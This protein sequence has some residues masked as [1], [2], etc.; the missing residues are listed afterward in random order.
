MTWPWMFALILLAQ[1]TGGQRADP[2]GPVAAARGADPRVDALVAAMEAYEGSIESVTWKQSWYAP[3]CT[4]MRRPDWLLGEESERYADSFWRWRQES[5]FFST[6]PPLYEV[7]YRRVLYFG[8]GQRRV[9]LP[10][11]DWRG[12]VGEPDGFFTGGCTLLRL[13][14]RHLDYG[15]H[16]FGRRPS[17][18]MR[19]AVALEYLEATAEVPWPGLRGKGALSDGTV[20]LEVR[21]DPD[22]GFAPRRF[23]TI[24]DRDG[25]TGEELFTVSYS[26]VD[27]VWIPSCGVC[28]SPYTE[29]VSDPDNPLSPAV[30]KD[31]QQARTLDGLPEG[32]RSIDLAAAIASGQRVRVIDA[33]NKIVEGPMACFRSEDGPYAPTVLQVSD[34]R[35]NGEVSLD[36]MFATLPPQASLMTGMTWKREPASLVRRL[37]SDLARPD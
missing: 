7:S 27:D 22:R 36:E 8:D 1:S 20:S 29:V 21:V 4:A 11:T 28:A 14:G 25:A 15:N 26:Q 16:E 3:P 32:C 13:L 33:T 10:E 12:I 24:R 30:Q 19:Q 9:A 5:R 35:L 2:Q 17:E 31:F 37:L 18:L 34:V 23:R 6:N